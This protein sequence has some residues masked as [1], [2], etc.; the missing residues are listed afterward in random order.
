MDPSADLQGRMNADMLTSFRDELVREAGIVTPGVD[1]TPYIQFAIEALTRDR[2][3]GYSA[4]D[5]ESSDETLPGHRAVPDQGLGY[6]QPTPIIE[7]QRRTYSN[8][9]QIAG[10]P[11]GQPQHGRLG[12]QPEA[13]NPYP[14]TRPLDGPQS[15]THYGFS[16]QARAAA[17]NDG[18]MLASKSEPRAIRPDE[19]VPMDRDLMTGAQSLKEAHGFPN[20]H[21]RPWLLR[22]ASFITLLLLCLLMVAALIFSAVYSATRNGFVA[23]ADSGG[24]YFLFRILPQ[25]LAAIIVIYTQ[26][27]VAAMFRILPFVRLASKTAE[28]RERSVYMDLYPGHTLW[29]KLI[30]EWEMWMFVFVSWLINLTLPLQSSLFTPLRVNETWRWGA[31]QGVVWTLVA[32]YVVLMVSAIITLIEWTKIT[33][34]GLIWD[35]RSLADIIVM[36]SDTNIAPQYKGTELASHRSTIGFA[37]RHRNIERLGYWG[38]QDGRRERFFYAIRSLESDNPR[39]RRSGSTNNEKPHPSS[40]DYAHDTRDRDLEAATHRQVVRH[41]HLPWCLRNNQLIFSVVAATILL[42]ALFVVSFLPSTRITNGFPPGLPSHPTPGG[43][44]PANFLYSFLPSLLG[45]IL[46]LLFQSLDLSF[47]I[48]QPWAALADNANPHNPGGGASARQSLLAD[49]AA[50]LPFQTTL[51][52]LRNGHYRVAFLSLLSTLFIFLPILGGGVFTALTDPATHN[53]V[54]MFPSLPVYGLVLALLVLYLV[55][56]AAALPSRH[57]FRLPHGVTCLAEVFGFLVNEDLLSE[58]CFKGVRSRGELLGKMGVGRT[59][60]VDE[61]GRWV[62]GT[63]GSGGDGEGVLGVRRVA[64]FTGRRVRKSQIRRGG[65]YG[66]A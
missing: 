54:R 64:R 16:P 50:C 63:G 18:S 25:L 58:K 20:L 8:A 13:L 53:S 39:Q 57:A 47:R 2:D 10:P 29:P 22:P 38:G 52:A 36:I 45:L 33:Q 26:C 31:V 27:V 1:D 61:G 40:I 66:V 56:L 9:P 62:L 42:V 35:P 19:V 30:D 65:R 28:E 4:N 12:G 3:T 60:D 46:Y 51:H 6:Y 17:W 7:Q 23:Y 34:T 59:G 43:F 48:L 24:Q 11:S 37:L 41:G 32:L 15:G 14:P 44:S 49:Y 5:S 55:G 21:Y